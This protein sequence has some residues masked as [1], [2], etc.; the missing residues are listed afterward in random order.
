MQGQQ[1]HAIYLLSEGKLATE[2]ASSA[3]DGQSSAGIASCFV[4]LASNSASSSPVVRAHMSNCKGQSG[5]LC[6]GLPQQ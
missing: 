3:M 5:T 1:R 4:N 2:V 6:P